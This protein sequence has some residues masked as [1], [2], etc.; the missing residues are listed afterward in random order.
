MPQPLTYGFLPRVGF[1]TKA[2]RLVFHNS[3]EHESKLRLTLLRRVLRYEHKG[4]RRGRKAGPHKVNVKSKKSKKS[5]K[6]VQQGQVVRMVGEKRL[7]VFW[8]LWALTKYKKMKTRP[9]EGKITKVDDEEGI[10]LASKEGFDDG[11]SKVKKVVEDNVK[12][13][14][15]AFFEKKGSGSAASVFSTAKKVMDVQLN[16]QGKVG[17]GCKAVALTLGPTASSAGLIA[18]MKESDKD[19]GDN[20][21]S[22]FRKLLGN[23]VFKRD[24][25]VG[26]SM[27]DYKGSS[28]GV[29]VVTSSAS[30]NSRSAPP[31]K[32]ARS[33]DAVAKDGL[34][35]SRVEKILSLRM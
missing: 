9:A 20:R 16:V 6:S 11:C 25:D 33:G 3:L 26:A 18:D 13:T 29:R 34:L 8:P 2:S 35:A 14:A 10:I 4:I 28:G 23:S 31:K 32:Q 27:A 15:C 17:E 22:L 24:T 12:A 30:S 1:Q 5:K 7:V 21:K 19:L